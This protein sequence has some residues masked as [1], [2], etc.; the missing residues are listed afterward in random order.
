VDV[1]GLVPVDDRT[2]TA[3]NRGVPVVHDKKSAAG[4]AFLRISARVDGDAVPLFQV[5]SKAGLMSRF[6]GMVGINGSAYS[7]A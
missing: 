4:A 2:I 1:L 5:E 7:H 6:K 3:A